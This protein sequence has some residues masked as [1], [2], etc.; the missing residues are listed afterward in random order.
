MLFGRKQRW[1]IALLAAATV[2]CFVDVR[3]RGYISPDCPEEHRTDLTVYTLAGRAFF[4][5]GQPYE[6]A[7]PR[8][9]TYLYPPMLALMMA[10][11]SVL[12]T[13]DQATVWFFISLA[14]CWGCCREARRIVTIVCDEDPAVAATWARWSG[15]LTAAAVAAALF[16]ALNCLQRGQVSLLKLYFLLLGLRWILGGRTYRAWLAGGVTLALPLVLKILPVV[17]VG[18]LLFMQ[19]WDL[20]VSYW[21]QRPRPEPVGRRFVA[22][23]LGVALG[24]VLF[25]LIV[26]ATLVGWRAN[27]HHLDTWAQF[28]LT[29]AD[30]GGMDPRSGN[31]HSTRNQS[32]HN[33]AYRFGNFA[34]H[35]IAGGPDDR[36][37]DEWGAPRM[38]MDGPVAQR[39]LMVAQAVLC[40]AL[41]A[42]GV[43]LSHG[44]GS[45]LNLAVGFALA[46][47]AMLV[48]SPVARGHYFIFLAPAGLL[49]PL[50]LDRHGRGRAGI[51]L[52]AI[53]PVL[54]I[55]HYALLPYAGRVGLLGLGTAAWFVAA[56][57]LMARTDRSVRSSGGLRAGSR[58][59]AAAALDRAA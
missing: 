57:V 50:W 54:S 27:L 44:D 40:L 48:V 9:W 1:L 36:L 43:R 25:L 29:K 20:V 30:D 41:L 37:V 16:P 53:L 49:V 24:V 15:W 58:I 38:A 31:S 13:Q 21:K 28:M 2:W 10:P 6:V 33:A 23:S 26:P 39:S 56:M 52:A 5:G 35:L 47:V 3:R 8:G 42:L 51:V 4:D 19:L 22:S 7:N 45:R 11:L 18:F 12:P 55:L 59:S 46:C 17:Q 32:L 34:T 14:L